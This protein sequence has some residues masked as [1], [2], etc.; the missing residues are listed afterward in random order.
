MHIVG[1]ETAVMAVPL[2]TPIGDSQIQIDRWGIVV[3]Q[4]H[5]ETGVTGFGYNCTIGVGGQALKTLIDEDITPKLCGQDVFLVKR[6]WEEVYLKTHFTGITGVSVQGLA[7]VEVA[8]WD[9]IAKELRRPLWKILGG[10]EPTRLMTYNTNGGWLSIP[11]H[12]LVDGIKKLVDDGWLGVKMKVGSADPYEDYV[13]VKAVRKAIGP[14]IRLMVDANNKWDLPTAIR[15]ITRLEEFDIFWIEEPLHPFDVKSHAQLAA[16]VRTPILVGENI[17]SLH[18]WRDFIEQRATGIVQADV[19]KLGGVSTWLEVAALAHA[20]SL[21]VV[22][23]AWDMM[24]LDVHLCAAIP[25]ALMVEYIPWIRKIFK[26]PVP[27]S[28]G[29]LRVPEEPGAGTE[30]KA[31]ALAEF[32][33]V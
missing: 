16:S 5:T 18:M 2:D 25:H 21:P 15:W 22:P 33:V 19:L 6:I 32:R 28:E 14:R 1:V 26:H 11:K 4:I 17:Y 13:R 3:V 20:N 23:A 30:I 7:A 24:Q 8:M 31:E 9:A 29:Y 27:F 10:Y 12:Q